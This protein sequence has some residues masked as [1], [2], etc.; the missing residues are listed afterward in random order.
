MPSVPGSSITSRS[1]SLVTRIGDPV[2]LG[3]LLVGLLAACACET[4]ADPFPSQSALSVDV[5]YSALGSQ[6]AAP[7]TPQVVLW[8]IEEL[9]ASDITGFD[10]DFSFLRSETCFYPLNVSAF[11]TL[12]RACRV[13]GL[14]L[15]PGVD[16]TARLKFRFSAIQ[17]RQ[18]ARPDLRLGADPDGDGFPNERDNCPIVPNPEQ[19]NVNEASELTQVGDACSILD[20]NE[21]PTIPDNDNDGVPNGLDN[22]LWYPNPLETDQTGQPDTDRDG[23]GDACARVAPVILDFSTRE[24]V[25]VCDVEFTTRPSI[26]SQFRLDFG[27]TGVLTCDSGFTGCTIDRTALEVSLLG[28]SDTFPCVVAP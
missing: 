11:L 9:T 28:T 20:S 25:V 18:A 5:T 14:T 24:L 1:S 10:G 7:G 2:R 22:C 23:I 6:S 13:S 3:S 4:A 19:E 8:S 21:S 15:T 17:L 16:R 27:R 26:P 12:N